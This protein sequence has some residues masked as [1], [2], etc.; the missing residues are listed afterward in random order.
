MESVLLT[1]SS[2]EELAG[3]LLEP[4]GAN[5]VRAV[6]NRGGV[7]VC[8]PHPQH[9]GNRFNPV[10]DAIFRHLPT[11]GFSSLRF[12][13]RAEYGGGVPERDDVVAAL[14]ELARRVPSPLFVAGYSF[15]AAVAL[16]TVDDRIAGIVAIAPPLSMMT[17]PAPAVPSAVITPRHDQFNPP[18]AAEAIAGS[19]ADCDLQTI[20][21]ADH[22]LVG[23]AAEVAERAAAWLGARQWP[24]APP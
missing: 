11:V 23:R 10:V 2:G 22:F 7:V 16:G 21:S 15:G 13:F 20:E 4:S 24:V 5:L 17:V 14:D 6:R 9:G 12:D 1:T 18:E 19:W 3:D 8:H